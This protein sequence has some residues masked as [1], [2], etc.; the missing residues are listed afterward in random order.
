M[1]AKRPGQSAALWGQASQVAAWG[2][3][4]AGMAKPWAAGALEAMA[5]N[6]GTSS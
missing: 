2:S 6:R 4:S 3:H 1:G 5:I